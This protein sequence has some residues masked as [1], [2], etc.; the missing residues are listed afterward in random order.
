MPILVA[1][2]YGG[3]T[4]YEQSRLVYEGGTIEANGEVVWQYRTLINGC[5]ASPWRRG[6]AIFGVQGLNLGPAVD[7]RTR[8]PV[9]CT[10]TVK[11]PNGR[12]VSLD[13]VP[14]DD[15]T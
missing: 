8:L 4:E 3:T 14:V 9:A 11:T 2:G 6:S 7:E 12:Q 10:V 5:V 13:L 1:K 15:N